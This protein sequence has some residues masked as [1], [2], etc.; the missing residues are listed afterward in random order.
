MKFCHLFYPNILQKFLFVFCANIG[1]DAL[2]Q[3]Q[4]H[5]KFLTFSVHF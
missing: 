2:E 5:R 3:A 4:L 1:T